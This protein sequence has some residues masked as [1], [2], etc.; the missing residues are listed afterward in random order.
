MANPIEEWIAEQEAD[1]SMSLE[2]F[3]SRIKGAIS[4]L[5]SRLDCAADEGI[6]EDEI[7]AEGAE[8]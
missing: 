5:R 4:I 6:D 1:S 3:Y 2:E 7:E 8:D